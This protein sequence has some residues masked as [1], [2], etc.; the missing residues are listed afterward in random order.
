MQSMSVFWISSITISPVICF[1]RMSVSTTWGF[2][3]LITSM[4]CSPLWAEPTTLKPM[5]AQS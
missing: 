4:A 3:S 2:V 5:S 1:I